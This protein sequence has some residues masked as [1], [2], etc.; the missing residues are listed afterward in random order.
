M[1]ITLAILVLIFSI[2]S[3]TKADDIKEVMIEGISIGDSLLDKYTRDEIKIATQSTKNWFVN[4]KYTVSIFKKNLETYEKLHITFLTDDKKYIV[5]AVAGL[6]D[7]P[8]NI[9]E[10]Y[11]KSE[12]IYSEIK[13]TLTDLEDMGKYEYNHNDD[14]KS[15]IVDYALLNDNDDEV[16]IACYDY[17][18]SYGGVDHLRVGV[19]LIEYANFLINDAYK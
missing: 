1:K 5:K 8:N 14:P 18:E 3:W 2:Q 11:K 19:R 13:A 17:S 7:Y 6:I 10:C 9:S 16:V 15:K 4:K 12:N